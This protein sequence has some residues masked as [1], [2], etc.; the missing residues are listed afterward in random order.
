M[1]TL[2]VTEIVTVTATVMV[3]VTVTVHRN[4]QSNGDVMSRYANLASRHASVT[5]P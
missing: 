2:T 1:V 3:T 5:S 4:G